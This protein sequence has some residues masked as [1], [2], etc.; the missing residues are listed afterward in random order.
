MSEAKRTKTSTYEDAKKAVKDEPK[1]T[2]DGVPNWLAA[3]RAGDLVKYVA[4]LHVLVASYSASMS[5]L[6]E[7]EFYMPILAMQEG[8]GA[9]EMAQKLFDEQKESLED[10]EE[11]VTDYHN[12]VNLIMS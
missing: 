2:A 7:N 11:F 12:Y 5:N 4:C 3:V 1:Y 9:I 8:S 6:E 10:D